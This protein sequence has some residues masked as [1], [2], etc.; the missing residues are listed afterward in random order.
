MTRATT[1][2]RRVRDLS[3]VSRAA[4][5]LA[6]ALVAYLLVL[7]FAWQAGGADAAS[8]SGI[9]VALCFGGALLALVFADV[10]G[11]VLPTSMAVYTGMLFR[12]MVPL[13]LGSVLHF[14]NQTL[15]E[16]GLL[17]Y[18][19]GF[20]FVTLVAEVALTLP[21]PSPMTTTVERN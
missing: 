3:T 11:N 9:A 16:G 4:I 19:V 8:A 18:L 21:L 7:P 17:Y 6:I 2:W 14:T 12:M 20:Y 10:F 13:L 1:L 15:A 5:L